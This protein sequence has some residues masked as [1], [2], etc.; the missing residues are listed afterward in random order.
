[1][2]FKYK[3]KDSDKFKKNQIMHEIL[4][5]RSNRNFS[6]NSLKFSA[7]EKIISIC[8]SQKGLFS[9]EEELKFLPKKLEDGDGLLKKKKYT[10]PCSGAISS[11]HTYVIINN[12]E[13]IQSGIYYYNSDKNSITLTSK[14]KYNFKKTV[15]DVF[16]DCNW[17]MDSAAIFLIFS[18]LEIKSKQYDLF[19]EFS[20]I[21]AGHLIQNLH[22]VCSSLKIKSCQFGSANKEFFFETLNIANKS[23]KNLCPVG[24]VAVGK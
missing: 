6:I 11:F 2:G 7:I 22:L 9:K 12:V 16:D 3:L 20:F 23:T 8:L 18:N 4:R 17:L 5:R 15:G 1:M 10:Y 14:K 19:Y 21:E 13:N 24:C